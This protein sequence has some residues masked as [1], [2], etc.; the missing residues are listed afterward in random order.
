[1]SGLTQIE[2]TDGTLKSIVYT[3]K[4]IKKKD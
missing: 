4:L 2:S 3:A 1:M